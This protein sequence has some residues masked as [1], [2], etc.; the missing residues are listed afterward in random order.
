MALAE[1]QRFAAAFRA[2]QIDIRLV[3]R[4]QLF[5]GG[6]PVGEAFE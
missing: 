2:G 1:R 5:V 3:Q 6:V 4:R